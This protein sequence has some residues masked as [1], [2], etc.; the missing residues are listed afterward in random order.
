MTASYDELKLLITEAVEGAITPERMGVLNRALAESGRARRFYCEFMEIHVLTEHLC[1]EKMFFDDQPSAAENEPARHDLFLQA[2]AEE[3]KHADSVDIDVPE[4]PQQPQP[5]TVAVCRPVRS[6]QFSRAPLAWVAVSAAAM[7]MLVLF[8]QLAPRK[9][10]YEVATVSDS[11]GAEWGDGARPA[12]TRLVTG[13]TPFYL[14][15][16]FVELA[17]DNNTEVVIEAPAEF[18]IIADD[19]VKLTYGRL[20]ANVPSEAVG[21]TVTS[22]KTKIIDLGTEFGVYSDRSGDLELHVLKGKTLLLPEKKV[23]LG[24]MEVTAGL[25]KKITSVQTLMDIPCDRRVF[26]RDIDSKQ[27]KVWRGQKWLDLADMIVGGD[28]QNANRGMAKIDLTTGERTGL[29]FVNALEQNPGFQASDQNAFIDGVFIPDQGDGQVVSSTG[30]GF[31]D[32]P[33]TSGTAFYHITTFNEIPSIGSSETHSLKLT[34]MSADTDSTLLLHPNAGITFDLDAIRASYPAHQVTSFVAA[35]GFPA[36]LSEK[37]AASDSGAG[38]AAAE[39]GSAQFHVLLDGRRLTT[40]SINMFT[41]PQTLQIPV[42]DGD[43]FL[44]LVSTDANQNINFDWVVL[45]NAKLVLEEH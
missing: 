37:R 43:R 10:G 19:Q 36:A 5:R 33:D 22:H 26:A 12:G 38:V 3:E 8:A 39:S 45:E 35:C 11:L 41:R 27:N 20:F 32:C 30:L 25:A 42:A 6:R 13:Y 9:T 31:E 28:G 18:Q 16:G 23:G 21:F 24:G 40:L 7:L 15:K 44:T 34:R 1:A 29:L 4:P 14:N 2:L 17:F